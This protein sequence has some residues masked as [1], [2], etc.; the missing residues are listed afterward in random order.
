[1][2]LLGTSLLS[3]FDS[4]LQLVV[5]GI[6][7]RLGLDVEGRFVSKAIANTGMVSPKLLVQ[8]GIGSILIGT[9]DL[10]QGYGLFH[11]RRW[12]EYLTAVAVGLLIPVE[13][14]SLIKKVT[15]L[16]VS[17]LVINVMIV[18]YLLKHKELFKGRRSSPTP[19]ANPV[20]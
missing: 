10:I 2:V 3:L 14:V 4:D 19:M 12:A 20:D 7:H 1:M 11:R 18:W 13:I 9:L 5:E 17:V 16:K 6:A 8:L 15:L